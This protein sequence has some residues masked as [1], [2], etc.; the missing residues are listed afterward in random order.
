M[1]T[2]FVK[3]KYRI[4]LEDITLRGIYIKLIPALFIMLFFL[5]NDLFIIKSVASA[6][7]RFIVIIP[8]ILLLFLRTFFPKKKKLIFHMYNFL[9]AVAPLMM[10]IKIFIHIN[11]ITYLTSSIIGLIILIFISSLEL[12]TNALFSAVIFGLPFLLFIFILLILNNPTINLHYILINIFPI[13]ILGYMA[14]L[15]RNNLL[16]KAFSTSF[17]LKLK[18]EEIKKHNE[19]L[20]TEDET[21]NKFFS[22]IS[23]DV[24]NPFNVVLGFLGLL[25]EDYDNFSDQERKTLIKETHDS[26]NVIYNFLDNLLKWSYLQ[27]Q[28]IKIGKETVHISEY[29]MEILKP[30]QIIAKTKQIQIINNIPKSLTIKIDK[31]TITTILGNLVN[32][33]I[34]FSHENSIIEI[35]G[36]FQESEIEFSVK[37]Y[38]VGMTEEVKNKLYRLD[39]KNST[40]GTNMEKGTGLGLILCKELVEKNNGKIWMESEAGKG[41]S[42]YFTLPA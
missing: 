31:Y 12:K 25:N 37:D 1:E 6:Y 17:L 39:E 11:H 42:F 8:I 15:N 10:Y 22:I 32:N 7:T 41:T 16:F 19:K 5:C 9:L 34:K 30:Y 14:N 33:A 3:R 35:S 2:A 23:H 38:G 28:G 29:V 27:L 40:L 13:A 18:N 24:K 36:K 4:Y 20:K 26:A 21:R